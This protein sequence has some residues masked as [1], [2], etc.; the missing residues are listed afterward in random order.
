MQENRLHYVTR[1]VKTFISEEDVTVMEWPAQSPDMSPIENVWKWLNEGAK[2]KNPWNV[3]DLWTYLKWE[4]EKIPVDKCKTLIR[5][6]SKIFHVVIEIMFYTSSFNA[7][8]S[9]I[10][11]RYDVSIIILITNPSARAGYD[12]RSIFKRALTGLKSEFFFS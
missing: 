10:S 2:E 7:L 5:S 1:S 8:W 4:C 9:I 3:E 12:T 11:F 6:R